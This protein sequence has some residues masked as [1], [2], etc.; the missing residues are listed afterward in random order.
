MGKRMLL[1]VNPFS[2]KR[3]A[4]NVL[5]EI[6]DTLCKE[7][8]DPAVHITQSRGDATL[9]AKAAE[10]LYDKVVCI[11]GDGTL[12]EMVSGLAQWKAAPSAG[13][14]PSGTTN[15]FAATLGFPKAPKE[16]ALTAVNG[17]PFTCD[18]GRFDDRFFVYIAAFGAFTDVAYSTDQQAKNI[19]GRLAYLFQGALELPS[20]QQGYHMKVECEDGVIED[21][22]IF[23]AVS[24]SLSIGGFK[25]LPA[26]EI[27][28][29]DGELEV[30][31]VRMPKNAAELSELVTAL[32]GQSSA[33]TG[34]ISSRCARSGSP[35]TGRSPGRWTAR[36]AA[37]GKRS[38]SPVSPGRSPS[39]SASARSGRSKRWR[40][41]KARRRKQTVQSI[42]RE[43]PCLVRDGAWCL[44]LS[45]DVCIGALNG[46]RPAMQA[47]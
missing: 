29:D 32:L 5:F 31:L 47:S 39:P 34:S 2:G 3:Q 36:T 19:F 9:A 28:L 24:N 41:S 27:F 30:L 37:A 15:D 6:L 45:F 14:I 22:F 44:F 23:G 25:G 46:T 4:R 10:G 1:I 17:E 42:K 21:D 7:G 20:L 16:A 11:G 38:A 8:W 43:T 40:C 13:Y 12:N 35:A 26:E 18:I 33:S